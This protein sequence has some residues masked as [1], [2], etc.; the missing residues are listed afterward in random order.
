MEESKRTRRTA[1]AARSAILRAAEREF[2]EFGTAGARIDRIAK[3]AQASKERLYA[4]FG[5]KNA[6]FIE[7]WEAVMVRV[8]TVVEFDAFD[9]PGYAERMVLHYFAHPEDLRMVSWARLEGPGAASMGNDVIAARYEEKRESVLAAQR[10]GVVDA[11]WDPDVLMQLVS[12]AT[13]YWAEDL[14]S[15]RP[16]TRAAQ[17]EAANNA[18]KAVGR[19]VAP[20][21]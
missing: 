6:L 2:A 18:S 9:L 5:D 10:A 19:L 11:S 13:T 21:R 1:V 3:S 14:F 8:Q 4:Y 7:V 17:Q 12:A 20:N 16:Q 15:T